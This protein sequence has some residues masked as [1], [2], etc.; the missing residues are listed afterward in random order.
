MQRLARPAAD[1]RDRYE[2]VVIGSGYGGAIAASRLARAGRQVCLLERGK[3][4]LPGQ[5]PDTLAEAL[6]EYQTNTPHGQ[7]GSRSNLYALQADEDISVVYGCGLGGTSLINAN[8]SLEMD[9]RVLD[10]PRW[11]EPLRGKPQALREGYRRAREML[12][13]NPFPSA[14][15]TPKKLTAHQKSAQRLNGEFRRLDLNVTFERRTNEV[16]IEQAACERCGDCVSGCNHGSKNTVLMNYLPD[17][18][19]HGAEIFTLVD[20]RHLE[21][22][23]DSWLVH[24]ELLDAGRSGF[25]S[26]AQ[27]V[28]AEV[29]VLAGGS[30][31]STEILLRSKA[32][33]LSLSTRV[34]QGFSGNGDVLGFAYNADEEI[35][36]VGWGERRDPS[37]RVGPTITSAIDLRG[38]AQPDRDMIIEDGVI[39]GFFRSLIAPT[40]AT[41]SELLGVD[42]DPGLVDEMQEWSRQTLSLASGGRFGAVENTQTFLVMADDGASGSMRLDDDR[43]R[44]S[45]PGVGDQP[46]FQHANAALEEATAALGG[47]YVQNPAWT[48]AFGRSLTTVHPLGGCCMADSAEHG[49]VNHLGQVFSDAT[50]SSV[51]ESLLVCDGAILPR[52]VGVNPLLSISALAERN[53]EL[54]ATLRGWSIDYR[55][56][57]PPPAPESQRKPGVQFTE[58]MKGFVAFGAESYEAGR[59]IGKES[60]NHFQFVLTIQ[61][62]DLEGMLDNPAH[63]SKLT[64]TVVSPALSDHP[65]SVS[66]GTL[67]ILRPDDDQATAKQMRYQMTLTTVEGDRYRFEGHK[68]VHDQ[69][70]FDLWSDTTTLYAALRPLSPRVELRG[71]AKGILR[72]EPLDFIKQVRTI[73]ARNVDGVSDRLKTIARFGDFFL[74]ELYKSYGGI[75]APATVHDPAAPPRKRRALRLPPPEIVPLRTEDGADLRLTRHRAGNRGP[76]LLAPGMGTSTQAFTLDT[77]DVNLAEYLAAH[78]YDVWLFDYRASS[79]VDACRTQFSLDEIGRFD[80]PSAVRRVLEITG[81]ESLQ[82]IAHCVASAGLFTSLLGGHLPRGVRSV[83]ASQFTPFV[84]TTPLVEA[85]S[86]LHLPALLQSLGVDV[87]STEFDVDAGFADQVYDTLLRLYPAEAGQLC[88]SPVCR[89]IRFM[90]GETFA[91]E[92]LNYATHRAVHEMFGDGNLALFRHLTAVVRAGKLVTR[93]GQDEYLPNLANVSVPITIVQGGRNTLFLPSASERSFEAMRSVRPDLRIERRLFEEYAHMDCFIGKSAVRD[94][95]PFLLS[96]LRAQE[97]AR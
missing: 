10:D 27:F 1:I 74:G 65:L 25:H 39:P 92:N 43:L 86:R 42:T 6:D 90:W 4:L 83:I 24:Y 88:D 5:Y 31:G 79:A 14:L 26:P 97:R 19:H 16:G 22:D 50:G 62:D 75:L 64:G 41:A 56:G 84:E 72:I 33:G 8:V 89:R 73:R 36:G 82:I 45:F 3:E 58:T 87:L 63:Q 49:V 48:K 93:A 9:A 70:G 47:T 21:R 54:F 91:H 35:Q 53:I 94:V 28:R 20:V 85:K 59:D 78:A 67:Q 52:S 61:S 95:F 51:Y 15:P 77:I 7:V 38:S 37:Q 55:L 40:L 11:P 76:V 57:V 32:R 68:K 46:T 71:E 18:T 44:L 30:L 13:P 29:V 81:A 12:R 34:G 66:E 96:E 69:P 2:V 60:G 17:A 23:G 80:Y